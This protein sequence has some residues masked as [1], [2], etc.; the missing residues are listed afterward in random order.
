[1]LGMSFDELL[2]AFPKG[3]NGLDVFV[4]AEDEAILLLVVFHVFE[5]VIMNITEKFDTGL[6]SPVIFEL[7]QKRMSE[8]EA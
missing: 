5:G 2:G 4:Q 7:S 8:E 3:G 6:H 1:M